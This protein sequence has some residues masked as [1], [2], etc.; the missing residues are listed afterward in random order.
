M[1]A[2]YANIFSDDLRDN[3]A[4]LRVPYDANFPIKELIN[5]VEGAVKYAAAKN[6]PYTPLQVFGIAYQLIFQTEM[7]NN[8]CKLWKRQDPAHKTWT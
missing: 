8:D 4:K 7:F 6:T 3:D 2:T 1:Y 5:Q